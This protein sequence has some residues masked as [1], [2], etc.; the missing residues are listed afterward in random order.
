MMLL[1]KCSVI[2]GLL[3]HPSGLY[4]SGCNLIAYNHE[5]HFAY[6][7]QSRI[8]N[9]KTLKYEI[10]PGEYINAFVCGEY[11]LYCDI[12]GRLHCYSK[13]REFINSSLVFDPELIKFCNPVTNVVYWNNKIYM[14][15]SKY[16]VFGLYTIDDNGEI[17]FV[18]K[19]ETGKR[20]N[21][22][23]FISTYLCSHEHYLYI[24]CSDGKVRVY[25]MSNEK[26]T[27]KCFWCDDVSYSSEVRSIVIDGEYIYITNCRVNLSKFHLN[28]GHLINTTNVKC[29]YV[30]IKSFIFDSLIYIVLYHDQIRVFTLDLIPTKIINI[31]DRVVQAVKCEDRLYILFNNGE[32]IEFGEL[33]QHMIPQLQHNEHIHKSIWC[34]QSFW[35]HS[36]IQKDIAFLFTKALLQ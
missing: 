24:G 15:I 11:I 23:P 16:I 22:Y 1:R 6:I 19:K 9:S 20:E 7:E 31:G 10:L 12:A 3:N 30:P 36:K 8:Y 28:S 27:E 5:L 35:P 29:M 18:N 4:A 13:H 14:K 25:D 32:M 26:L 34:W 21:E 33:Y 2:D 17:K